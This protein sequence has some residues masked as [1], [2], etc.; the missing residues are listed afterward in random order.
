MFAT[1][2]ITWRYA[3]GYAESWVT[4][5]VLIRVILC[6]T[7]SY[8]S[9]LET[10]TRTLTYDKYQYYQWPLYSA[11]MPYLPVVRN[12]FSPSQLIG[13]LFGRP[14]RLSISPA[15]NMRLPTTDWREHKIHI[16]AQQRSWWAMFLRMHGALILLYI[17]RIVVIFR[18]RAEPMLDS[19]GGRASVSLYESL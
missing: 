8:W 18:Y 4:W 17:W 15:A 6:E 19:N 10:C 1:L 5:Y 3:L 2:D 14:I 13:I 9:P 16:Q 12:K 7:I 11:M